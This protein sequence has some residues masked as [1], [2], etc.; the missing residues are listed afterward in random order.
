MTGRQDRVCDRGS[1]SARVRASEEIVPP[2]HGG[3]AMEAFHY[4]V[5]NR[6]PS[7]VEEERQ[8]ALV[9]E[10]VTHRSAEQRAWWFEGTVGRGPGDELLVHGL[11]PARP[12]LE[13]TFGIRATHIV[14]D[15]VQ[16][17]E[18]LDRDRGTG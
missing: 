9:V 1:L 11:R 7:V 17:L 14:L 10:E 4:P 15:V 2:S 13:P 8:G 18:G 16:R 3:P 5:V 12:L 6:Q